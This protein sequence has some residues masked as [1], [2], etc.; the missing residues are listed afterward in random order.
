MGN[1]FSRKSTIE[2]ISHVIISTTYW[3]GTGPFSTQGID[4]DNLDPDGRDYTIE[5]DEQYMND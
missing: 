4:Y 1:N 3:K 5:Y 2:R